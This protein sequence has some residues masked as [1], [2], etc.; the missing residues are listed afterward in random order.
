MKEGFVPRKGKVYPLL[1][2]VREEVR[3]FVKEQLRKGYIWPSKLPQTVLVF[4]V[5][6]KDG[7]KR[8]VQ[9]YK[10]L[11]EWMVKNNYPLPL[12]SDVL[13]NIGIK[14]LFTKMDLRWGY[15]NIRIKE[16][17]EWKAAFTMPE[18]LFELTVMFF[19]LTNSL[20][21]FQVMMNKLLRDL[22]NT[23]KV[24]VFIDDVIVGTEMEEG[25]DELVVEVIKRLEEN[26]LYMKLEKCKWKVREVDFL[27]V[28]IGLEGI[29][30]EK[31]K[32]K[33][34]LEWPTP[35]C[36]KDIQK[37][38]GLANYYRQFIEG[39][40]MVAR[41]LHNLVKKDKKWE[42]TEK[43]EKAFQE[44]KEQFTKKLVLVAPDIDKKMRME[45]DA[46]DYV[47]GGVLSME[48]KDGLWKP[49]AFL[50]KLLNEMKRN[51]EIHDKEMLAIVRGLEAWRHLL[52]GAQFKFEI[53][54]DHKNLEYFMKAQKLNRR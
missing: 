24:A 41:P 35:K 30:M 4:F 52:E 18:G 10:Y 38:L 12:I 50:S 53:W 2:E 15:N 1:R 44:L 19:G 26:D 42:W 23:G 27:G 32:V 33:G 21:T 37:F 51:Y 49:V 6:K 20:A 25:H 45:V 29:K 7:K 31:E 47:M 14:K 28:V 13:E 34:V 22:I 39:F 54:T 17:N 9:D 11:N 16:R 5:G 36:V 46:S 3:E 8:M 48:C 40:A 43:E